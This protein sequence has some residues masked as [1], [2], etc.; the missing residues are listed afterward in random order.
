MEWSL[1]M[2]RAFGVSM[3]MHI[4]LVVFLIAQLT[5][6][7]FSKGVAFPYFVMT[8]G[9]LWVSILLHEFGHCFACRMV[10]GEADEILMWPLGGLA[11]CRPPHDWKANLI[12][13]VGGPMVNVVLM[14][15]TSIGVLAM[16]AT[17][18]SL[19][20]NPFQ[21]WGTLFTFQQ[22]VAGTS[23]TLL[24]LKTF[25]WLLYYTNLVLLAFN[26][27]LPM[28]PMDGGRIM[29][30][31]IWART[32]YRRSML[33]SCTVGLATALV[34]GVYAMTT[35]QVTLMTISLFSGYTC[36]AERR[37]IQFADAGGDEMESPYAASL[38]PDR[39]VIADAKRRA[40]EQ[41]RF[42]RE[43]AKHQHELDRIL[44]KI[45]KRGMS[46]LTRSEKKFLEQD[47]TRR[48]QA[49]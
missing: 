26:V 30:A 11:T 42:E 45:S 1:P 6:G 4:T 37:R 48:R 40:V 5:T 28:F 17:S 38:R 43:E 7:Y 15:F 23:D 20:F 47:T 34:L 36:W 44:D 9:C 10:R 24:Y 19:I 33:I 21:P 31:I 3:R 14:V 12:T 41:E 2:G 46:A 13:T 35:N 29:Q 16:G 22:E 32:D 25:V 27:L 8:M 49:R 18:D 39:D